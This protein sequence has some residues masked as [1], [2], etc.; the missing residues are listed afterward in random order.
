[1]WSKRRAWPFVARGGILQKICWISGEIATC[2]PRNNF[3]K[4]KSWANYEAAAL[5]WHSYIVRIASMIH[6]EPVCQ[7]AQNAVKTAGMIVLS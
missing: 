7:S 4:K 1:M 3:W 6:V 2:I 5:N